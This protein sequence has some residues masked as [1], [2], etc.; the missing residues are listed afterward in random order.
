MIA[1]TGED[2]HSAMSL[3]RPKR[4]ESGSWTLKDVRVHLE[5][6][7]NLE[8]WTIPY[9]MTVMYSI[10]D[11]GHPDFRRIQSVVHQE[12]LHAELAANVYNSFP[13]AEDE[14]EPDK[15]LEIGPFHYVKELG[16]PHLDFGLD[17]EAVEKYGEPDAGLGPLDQ[18]RIGTMCLI[19]LPESAPPSFD[20]GGDEYATIGDFYTAL[21]S[22]MEENT[23]FVR[24]NRKQVAHFGRFYR[25][26]S[27]TTVTGDGEAGLDQALELVKVITEQGEGRTDGNTDI[28]RRYRNTADGY[29]NS[30]SHFEKFNAI[31]ADVLAGRAPE[32][33]RHTGADPDDGHGD[34]RP[35]LVE[36]FGRLISFIQD[37]F[38][39]HRPDHPHFGELMPTVGANILTCWRRGFVPRFSDVEIGSST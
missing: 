21:M 11:I 4:V 16:V 3:A 18:V 17:D 14:R 13:P 33:Y 30:A 8:L 31:R 26:L 32:V 19:E 20:P 7:V 36:N 34:P 24:G 25:G 5:Y 39:G 37:M 12:M 22:G 9:Y 29:E 15:G 1:S 10:K 6:A 38:N 23:R 2:R 35:V 28:E 27:H